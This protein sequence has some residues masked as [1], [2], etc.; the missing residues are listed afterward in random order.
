MSPWLAQT[1]DVLKALL[2]G[3]ILTVWCLWAVNWRKAWPVMAVGG[4]VPL[5]LVAWAFAYFWSLINPRALVICGTAISNGT[6]QF[7]AVTILTG[8]G[9][10]CGWLQGVYGWEPE[11]VSLD[12]PE[13]H[14]HGDHGHGHH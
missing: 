1:I 5:V 6:W 4:W 7:F 13:H 8:V 10:F 12:P 14:D 11:T 9:L 2:P 3:G